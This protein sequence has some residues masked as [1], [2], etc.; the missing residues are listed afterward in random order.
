MNS[1]TS[2]ESVPF[3]PTDL[4]TDDAVRTYVEM[5]LSNAN[6]STIDF[7]LSNLYPAV[8]DGTYP[9]YSQFGRAV[10]MNTDFYF[11]C[12]TNFIAKALGNTSH[13]YIFAYPPGYH[14]GDVNYVFWNGDMSAVNGYPLNA[15][16]A[17]TLQ[18]YIMRFA[19]NSGDP[20]G[21]AL[22]VQFP[23]YGSEG[24]VLSF[25]EAGV[26]VRTDDMMNNRCEWIQQA[27]IDGLISHM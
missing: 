26:V 4:T 8:F 17:V 9:W 2:N 24:S 11:A 16:L 20:N 5:A 25:E 18:D 19:M 14:A 23:E 27:M 3:V 1:H 22:P 13:N 10:Q 6:S 15:T 12:S 21:D 7:L